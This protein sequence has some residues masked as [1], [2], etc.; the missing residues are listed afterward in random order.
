MAA[1]ILSFGKPAP[2]AAGC[3]RMRNDTTTAVETKV[4]PAALRG[5]W[6]R[7][8]QRALNP[9]RSG[10]TRIEL[11]PV[12]VTTSKLKPERPTPQPIQLYGFS[13]QLTDYGPPVSLGTYWKAIQLATCVSCNSDRSFFVDQAADLGN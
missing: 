5:L 1:G 2:Y 12:F 7:E 9:E 3:R 11:S 13:F 8:A 4:D 10:C 6:G